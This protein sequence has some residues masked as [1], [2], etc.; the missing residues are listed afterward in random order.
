MRTRP[1]ASGSPTIAEPCARSVQSLDSG[2][3][4]YTVRRSGAVS[5]SPLVTAGSRIPGTGRFS[6]DRG[7][8]FKYLTV[9]SASTPATAL[10]ASRSPMVVDDAI[11]EEG[12]ALHCSMR[13]RVAHRNL[14][15]FQHVELDVALV[16]SRPCTFNPFH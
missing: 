11:C 3:G 15:G 10:V 12:I 8:G 7:F 9:E 13:T 14:Y 2:C 6:S 4:R 16:I 5:G 1:L